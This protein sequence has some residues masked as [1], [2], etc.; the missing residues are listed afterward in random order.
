MTSSRCLRKYIEVLLQ[1]RSGRYLTSMFWPFGKCTR[2]ASPWPT[3]RKWIITMGALVWIELSGS[4]RLVD[5]E[6]GGVRCV[7]EKQRDNCEC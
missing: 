1:A 7:E 3:L 2:V 5:G 6:L 4:S